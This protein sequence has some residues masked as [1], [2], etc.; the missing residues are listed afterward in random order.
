GLRHRDCTPR[1]AMKVLL[2]F[3][4]I[5]CEVDSVGE[6]DL[7]L[8]PFCAQNGDGFTCNSGRGI[9][10]IVQCRNGEVVGSQ[11][12]LDGCIR[13]P[14]GQPDICAPAYVGRRCPDGDGFYCGIPSGDRSGTLFH[15][16][17]G[18]Y[19][20]VYNCTNGCERRPPGV[21]DRCVQGGVGAPCAYG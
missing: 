2:L 18:T 5:G 16:A 20:G 17:G 10:M 15:C 14:P 1:G 6:H 13:Y 12:C 4:V 11:T 9:D 7:T 8:N 3:L 19:T 21:A